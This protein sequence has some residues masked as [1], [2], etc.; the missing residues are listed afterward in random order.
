MDDYVAGYDHGRQAAI[1]S[2]AALRSAPGRKFF[3]LGGSIRA[4]IG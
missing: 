1:T 4:D 3:E 2:T